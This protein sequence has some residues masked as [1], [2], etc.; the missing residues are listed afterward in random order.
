[1]SRG[2]GK[3]QR[4]ILASLR[5]AKQAHVKDNFNYTGAPGFANL[6]H[7]NDV[8]DLRGTL[9]Y[10]AIRLSEQS[11]KRKRRP[12]SED[13]RVDQSFRI[14]FLNAAHKLVERGLLI[15]CDSEDAKQLRFVR[16]RPEIDRSRRF[17]HPQ[18]HQK[19]PAPE[20][21]RML[22]DLLKQAN[23]TNDE[24]AAAQLYA[25]AG[26]IGS[27]YAHLDPEKINRGLFAVV[28]FWRDR[29]SVCSTNV[30]ESLHRD[31]PNRILAL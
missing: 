30:S 29:E 14:T 31:F 24:I 27:A 7:L 8:Y 20:L 26:V 6:K 28:G 10:L 22:H 4:L 16:M 11:G 5:P 17:A 12:V 3:M 25:V 19:I 1:M 21:I 23:T 9:P 13:L 15:R 18:T 2:L